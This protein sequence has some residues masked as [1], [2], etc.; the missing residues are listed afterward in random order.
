MQLT[1]STRSLPSAVSS[2]TA[3][4]APANNASSAQRSI[5]FSMMG[6]I[7][8]NSKILFLEF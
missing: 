1:E 8:S 7:D 3:T 2:G 6:I 4:A 5:A